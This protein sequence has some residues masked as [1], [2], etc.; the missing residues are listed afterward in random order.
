LANHPDLSSL[1]RRRGHQ[2]NRKVL[3]ARKA[4]TLVSRNA[5]VML[6]AGS[7]NCAIAD[8]LP[9]NYGLTVVTNAPDIAQRLMDR[10]GI[11][12][13]LIGGRIGKRSGAA[14]GGATIDAIRRIRADVS[15]PGTCAI[16]PQSGVWAINDEEALV[17]QAMVEAAASAVVVVTSDKFGAAAMHHVVPWGKI[18]QLMVEHDTDEK[19]F[20]ACAS[21]VVTVRA[22]ER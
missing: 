1:E 14:V 15:F 16:D 5:L 8:A 19:L 22:D 7:T 11:E 3:L 12:I 18:E 20:S 4:V 13:L 6:D 9:D 21:R 10:I 17:K 2:S